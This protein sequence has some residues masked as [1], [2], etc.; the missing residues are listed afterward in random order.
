MLRPWPDSFDAFKQQEAWLPLFGAS[1][2]VIY[3]R[4]TIKKMMGQGVLGR[5]FYKFDNREGMET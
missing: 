5:R 3:P 4:S 2:A 1:K